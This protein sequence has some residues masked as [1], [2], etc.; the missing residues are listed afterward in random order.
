MLEIGPY[1]VVESKEEFDKKYDS[2]WERLNGAE[3]RYKPENNAYPLYL[4]Y[5]ESWDPRCCGSYVLTEKSAVEEH[6]QSMIKSYEDLLN[7]L[8]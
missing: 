4:R 3:Y 1:M 5:Y 8:P 7:N 6:L 2:R